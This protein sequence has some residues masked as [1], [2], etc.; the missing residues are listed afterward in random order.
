MYLVMTDAAIRAKSHGEE[1]LDGIVL[2]LH[3]REVRH[4]PYGIPQWLE[5]VSRQIGAVQSQR[6]YRA[7]ADGQIEIPNTTTFAPCLATV[8]R[9][10]RTFQPG[11]PVESYGWVR[12]PKVPESACR[13]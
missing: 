7:M 9:S 8:R 13:F 6:M 5:L 10:V 12:N 3:R 1:S 2:E 4:Q 11:A